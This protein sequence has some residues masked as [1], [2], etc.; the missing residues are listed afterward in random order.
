MDKMLQWTLRLVQ[1]VTVDVV[2][3]DVTSRQ[4]AAL[5]PLSPLPPRQ[6]TGGAAPKR[7]GTPAHAHS[8]P[9]IAVNMAAHERSIYNVIAKLVQITVQ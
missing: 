9:A 1:N 6:D 2:N 5:P 7:G 4:L 8:L 3:L